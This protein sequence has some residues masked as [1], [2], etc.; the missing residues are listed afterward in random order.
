M[1]MGLNVIYRR[2]IRHV[3]VSHGSCET[4]KDFGRIRY[5]NPLDITIVAV[6]EFVKQKL[7]ERGCREDRI[8][9]AP[10]F[11]LPEQIAAVPKRGKFTGGVKRAAAAGR[12]VEAKRFDL[13]LDAVDYRRELE[14][15]SIEIA[16][17]GELLESLR[18]APKPA[19]PTSISWASRTTCRICMRGPI[20]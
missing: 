19:M 12:L 14:D 6:S 3:F 7:I 9:V 13:L 17:D 10:N 15:V 16:G 20:C 8:E 11:L 5:L 1:C 4:E 2:R 18:T